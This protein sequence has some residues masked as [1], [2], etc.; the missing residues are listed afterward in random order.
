MKICNCKKQC[1]FVAKIC[2]RALR[3]STEGYLAVAASTPTSAR[4]TDVKNYV[5][6]EWQN[7]IPMMIMMVCCTYLIFDIF[8]HWNILRPKNFATLDHFLAI[9]HHILCLWVATDTRCYFSFF[10]P[11]A[12]S[13]AADRPASDI[14]QFR[15]DHFHDI[16]M[17]VGE[18]WSE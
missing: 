17:R 10:S 7:K 8:L 6:R 16:M 3:A 9:F 15:C 5:L 14:V 12:T 11:L 13:P 18:C 1:F 2:E 4:L